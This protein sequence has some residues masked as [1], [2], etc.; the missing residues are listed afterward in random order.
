MAIMNSMRKSCRMSVHDHI[1]LLYTVEQLTFS[2]TLI[3]FFRIGASQ[4]LADQIKKRREVKYTPRVCRANVSFH[5]SGL[6]GPLLPAGVT[7]T[8]ALGSPGESTGCLRPSWHPQAISPHGG[9][10]Q[11][12]LPRTGCFHRRVWHT[13]RGGRHRR[14]SPVRLILQE[15]DLPAGLTEFQ[16]PS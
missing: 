16:N 5:K 15:T 12:A 4:H 1:V 11:V 7:D 6:Q 10:P 2:C 3:E 9:G 8:R 14:F 13:Q